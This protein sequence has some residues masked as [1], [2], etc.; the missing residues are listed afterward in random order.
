MILNVLVFVAIKKMNA[1]SAN[2]GPTKVERKISCW[3]LTLLHWAD[4]LLNVQ[5]SFAHHPI[6][7][8]A[9]FKK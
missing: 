4:I 3:G 5:D 6:S 8:I 9:S 7:W 1:H 2:L